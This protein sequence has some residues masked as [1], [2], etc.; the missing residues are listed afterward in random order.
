[1]IVLREYPS[2]RISSDSSLYKGG[3]DFQQ[4]K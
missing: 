3:G 1:M 2:M 4:G